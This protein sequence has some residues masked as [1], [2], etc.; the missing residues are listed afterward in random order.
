M[1]QRE[2]LSDYHI[3]KLL[4]QTN[5]FLDAGIK[6]LEYIDETNVCW[7]VRDKLLEVVKTTQIL[8]EAE[9]NIPK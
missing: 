9:T 8:C 4:E 5:S 3:E 1:K 6:F 7:E 2:R